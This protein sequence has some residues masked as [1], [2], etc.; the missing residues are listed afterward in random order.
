MAYAMA[1]APKERQYDFF[2]MVRGYF[3]LVSYHHANVDLWYG[4]ECML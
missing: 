4:R 3:L 2:E 1:Y